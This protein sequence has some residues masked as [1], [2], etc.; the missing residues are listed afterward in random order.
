[1]LKARSIQEEFLYRFTKEIIAAKKIEV[2]KKHL[3]E[4]ELARIKRQVEIEKLKQKFSSYGQ[5]EKPEEKKEVKQII[6]ITP[7]IRPLPTIPPRPLERKEEM[8]PSIKTP[9][10]S[11]PIIQPKQE[12]HKPQVQQQ[13]PAP[14]VMTIP[15]PPQQ[16]ALQ[17]GEIDLGK[18]RFLV[19]DPLVTYI[20]C[21]GIEKNLIIRR[22]GITT[23]TQITLTKE[24]ILTIIKNFSETAKIPLIEGMLNAR[25]SNLEM[26]AVVSEISTNSFIIKKN[27]IPD[28]N[29]PISQLQKP[30]MQIPTMSGVPRPNNLMPPTNNIFK[31]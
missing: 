23:R 24:E 13:K 14:R 17:E 27:P 25:V 18:I 26:S 29:K 16:P 4:R 6:H 7:P 28:M 20:E 19:R 31:K 9:M 22:A 15:I 5:M 21:P 12:P 30:M 8:K 2:L 3:D 11:A 1:M 10:Q